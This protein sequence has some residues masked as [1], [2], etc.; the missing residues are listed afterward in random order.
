MNYMM[1]VLNNKLFKNIEN[2]IIKFI[3][4]KTQR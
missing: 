1:F 2:E 3:E 4:K